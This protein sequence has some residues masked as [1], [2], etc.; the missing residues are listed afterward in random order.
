M[1]RGARGVAG[2][3]RGVIVL[4][5]RRRRRRGGE[6]RGGGGLAHRGTVV[7]VVRR[8]RPRGVDAR[9]RRR[10]LRGGEEKKQSTRR[11]LLSRARRRGGGLGRRLRLRRRRRVDGFGRRVQINGRRFNGRQQSVRWR[12]G[13]VKGS[14]VLFHCGLSEAGLDDGLESGET[15]R[16]EGGLAVRRGVEAERDGAHGLY[17]ARARLVR[18]R[19]RLQQREHLRRIQR[20]AA[21][22]DPDLLQDI[23]GDGLERIFVVR[24]LEPQRKGSKRPGRRA[25]CAQVHQQIRELGLR[26]LRRRFLGLFRLARL[27]ARRRFVVAAG[28]KCFLADVAAAAH[29]R[30][31]QVVVDLDFKSAKGSFRPRGVEAVHQGLHRREED[32]GAELVLGSQGLHVLENS[33][34]EPV[35]LAENRVQSGHGSLAQLSFVSGAQEPEGQRLQRR[36]VQSLGAQVD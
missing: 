3:L 15:K 17:Q 16:F 26:Q 11:R 28:R 32:G 31:A 14:L 29:H 13:R 35:R 36:R 1:V 2:R 7:V 25:L 33:E 20:R 9:R 30:T 24:R 34:Q 23:H 22:E 10:S 21:L 8:R 18:V 27:L 4:A 12:G 6:L 5:D 19:P